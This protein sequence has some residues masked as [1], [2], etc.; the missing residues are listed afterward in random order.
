MSSSEGPK[1]ELRLIHVDW[2]DKND[3]ASIESARHSIPLQRNASDEFYSAEVPAYPEIEGFGHGQL[4]VSTDSDTT[5]QIESTGESIPMGSVLDSA[6]GEEWWIEKGEWKSVSSSPVAPGYHDAPSCRHG[7]T[8]LLHIGNQRC[9]VHFTP[10]GFS[11]KE[12]DDLLSDFQDECWQ[13][14]LSKESYTTAPKESESTVPGEEFIEHAREVL[15]A[16]KRVLKRPQ[17]ELREVQSLQRTSRV[18]PV[19]RTFKELAS[20]GWTRKVTGRDHRPDYDTPENQYV[21]SIIE[22]LLRAVHSLHRGGEA[23]RDRLLGQISSMN[24]R[25]EDMKEGVTQV[26]PS[27]LENFAEREEERVQEWKNRS[28]EIFPVGPSLSAL[29]RRKKSLQEVTLSFKATD[30]D[31]GYNSITA[32]INE[33]EL[34]KSEQKLKKGSTS[35][36]Q[37]KCDFKKIDFFKVGSTYKIKMTGRVDKR[38]GY[39]VCKMYRVESASLIEDKKIRES[40]Y[41][42]KKAENIRSKEDEAQKKVGLQRR[43]EREEQKRERQSLQKRTQFYESIRERW[44]D[45]LEALRQLQ[46]DLSEVRRQFEQHGI[47]SSLHARYP[48]TMVFVE[49]PAYRA[50]HAA[51]Q[52]LQGSSGF[53]S[54][55]FDKLLSLGDLSILDLPTVYERWCLLQIIR[56]LEEEYGFEPVTGNDNDPEPRPSWRSDLI[57]TVCQ[58][59]EQQFTVHFRSTRLQRHVALTYQAEL[60]NGRR[61]DFLLKVRGRNTREEDENYW[62]SEVRIVLDAKFKQ[63]K[64][65]QNGPEDS[66][67]GHEIDVLANDKDYTERGQGRENTVFALHPSIGA[68]PKPATSQKWATS[69]YYGGDMT[70]EWQEKR[71]NHQFGGVLV[72]PRQRD[73]IKRLIAMALSYPGEINRGVYKKTN[74]IKQKLFCIFC[75][76]VSMNSVQTKGAKR[77]KGHW[78]QC[79]NRRCEHFMVL[80]FCVNCGHRLWKHGSH[81]TFHD[82]HPLSPYN[83]KC[84]Q[85]GSYA[86]VSDEN[87][88]ES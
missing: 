66:T 85:C 63:Y 48:G 27:R 65:A 55:L 37:F 81:W 45:R 71:P 22:R 75:G 3:V 61:P 24:K 88:N 82:T 33:C 11:K 60:N 32:R 67:L 28:E 13:L 5:P 58:T 78:Y 29:R 2:A 21:A 26:D 73:D 23:R 84:P 12:F 14:I 35:Y 40:R 52:D 25:I 18:R 44:T 72:R 46:R 41:L 31:S 15:Q 1:F 64:G 6:T 4:A 43:R 77:S 39:S 20:K 83:I 38:D 30:S 36:L 7:G 87:G 51:Y 62:L 8:V 74:Q 80:H 69:S 79:S 54:D 17:R 19:P 57:D 42:R 59:S 76:G 70:F 49:Q 53:R 47:E 56:V 34:K 68:V 16:A 86:P 9:R 10:P 50:A